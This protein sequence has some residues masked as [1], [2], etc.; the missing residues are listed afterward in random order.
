MTDILHHIYILD[1]HIGMANFKST[2][3]V[4]GREKLRFP[5]GRRLGGIQNQF[6]RFGGNDKYLLLPG[7][8][9]P[10]VHPLNASLL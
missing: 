7:V 5:L 4:I 3:S 10:L 9:T 2:H 6:G 1:K 8:G